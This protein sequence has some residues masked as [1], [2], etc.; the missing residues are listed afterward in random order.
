MTNSKPCYELKTNK[1]GLKFK[2]NRRY[3]ERVTESSLRR[4]RPF[5]I[6]CKLT[7][8]AFVQKGMHKRNH[9]ILTSELGK[10]SAWFQFIRCKFPKEYAHFT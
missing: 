9:I 3:V 8:T 1:T 7:P 2:T 6:R 5:R 10:K 4:T